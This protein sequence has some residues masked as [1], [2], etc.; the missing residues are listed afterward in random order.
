MHGYERQRML[1]SFHDSPK[2]RSLPNLLAGAANLGIYEDVM[3]T[4]LEKKQRGQTGGFSPS[5]VV[6]LQ[7][8]L[9]GEHTTTDDKVAWAK[10]LQWRYGESHTADEVYEVRPSPCESTTQ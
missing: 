9:Q 2:Y 5:A 10:H 3:K 1:L 8:L 7:H 4:M 6:S